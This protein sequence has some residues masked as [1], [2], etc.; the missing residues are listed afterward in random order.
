MITLFV[1]SE[2]SG[3][4]HSFDLSYQT[5]Q[6]W[7]AQINFDKSDQY[8]NCDFSLGYGKYRVDF[9]VSSIKTFTC[10]IDFSDANFTGT[11]IPNQ[12][13][14]QFLIEYRDNGTVWAKFNDPNASYSQ[15]SNEGVFEVWKQL[16]TNYGEQPRS[17]GNFTDSQDPN[18]QYHSFPLDATTFGHFAHDVP[19]EVYLNLKVTNFNANIITGKTITVM[20]STFKLDDGKV[21]TIY[22]GQNN[23]EMV[24]SGEGAKF[25]SGN[26]SQVIF[27]ENYSLK[28]IEGAAITALGT[29]FQPSPQSPVWKGINLSGPGHSIIDGCVFNN[30]EKSIRSTNCG[31]NFINISNNVFN[32]NSHNYPDTPYFGIVV[33]NG[34]SLLLYNNDFI[35]PNDN[36][37]NATGI[38]IYNYA[39]TEEENNDAPQVSINI[40][41]N[42]FYG[43]NAHIIVSSL[44][45]SYITA[46]IMSNTFYNSP[47]NLFLINSGGFVKGN[48]F[49]NTGTWSSPDISDNTKS[50]IMQYV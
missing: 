49:N 9:Y 20:G 11:T 4:D 19:E 30:A 47:V 6:T 35:L 39:Q 27:P 42:I 29:K 17:R 25:E 43:G 48:E 8:I 21:L 5:N 32:V 3:E 28:I 12:Y 15:I 45:E 38:G 31:S 44:S 50:V 2:I 33:Y 26:N 46:N 13:I 14:Q 36:C 40:T 37:E 34:K 41:D 7:Y 1:L 23:K 18:S 22:G 10:D 16:G 24:V